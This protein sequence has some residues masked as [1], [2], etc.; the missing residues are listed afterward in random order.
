MPSG[1]AFSQQRFM[2]SN[3]RTDC[4]L[5]NRRTGAADFYVGRHFIPRCRRPRFRHRIGAA[6]ICPFQTAARRHAGVT[7]AARSAGATV[8]VVAGAPAPPFLACAVERVIPVD[9]HFSIL[10]SRKAA[11]HFRQCLT[12]SSYGINAYRPSCL[13]AKHRRTPASAIAI[14]FTS[15]SS[16]AAAQQFIQ[17]E[18]ASRVGLIQAMGL[19]LAAANLAW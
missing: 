7:A 16:G 3:S 13:L 5:S 8:L 14:L 15:V 12:A 6:A 19:G 10:M 11:I 18:P 2:L 4:P 17:A 9:F 1:T